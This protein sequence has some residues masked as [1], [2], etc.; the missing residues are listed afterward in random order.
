MDNGSEAPRDFDGLKSLLTERHPDLPKRLKQ[1]A[2]FA[3]RHP[4]EV[5]FGTAALIAERAG[6]QPSTLVRLAQ[7]VGYAGFSEMQQVFRARMK[8]GWPDYHKRL[9]AL[10]AVG[11]NARA[12]D[13][14]T[15]F[16]EAA[17]VSIERLR[18]TLEPDRL[19]AAV[20]LLAGADTIYLIAA[21]RVFPLT[22]YLAYAFA[23]MGVRCQLI[24]HVGQLGA[25]QIACARPNDA[26]LAISFTPYAPS[27]VDLTAA[28]FKAGVPVLSITDSAFS[29]LV[30][31]S[32]HWL[33]VAE[34]DYG[35]FRS[36]SASFAVAMTLAVAVGE[37]REDSHG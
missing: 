30:Q 7:A 28:A 3:F 10:K 9:E 16:T 8:E 35:A 19:E 11:P 20:D 1:A 36:L 14:L 2:G 22:A 31:S 26:V 24:D 34:A 33:E 32:T 25:E 21:R 13:L 12:S 27:T 4:D 17:I 6:V 15:G 29:P 23:K 5:A 18:T 37:K